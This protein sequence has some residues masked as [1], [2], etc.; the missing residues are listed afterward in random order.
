MRQYRHVE[1][2][3][4]LAVV[5]YAHGAPFT[6]RD[7]LKTAVDNCLAVNATG[8]VCCETANC[9]PA[10][11]DEMEGWDV[12]SVTD[13]Q[14]M[15]SSAWSFNANI[16]GWDVSSVTD[17]EYMFWGASAFNADIS[18]WD[19]TSVA[20]IGFMFW[21][22]SA[23]N[24]DISGWDV[25]SVEDMTGMF[26]QASAFNADISV[27]DVSSVTDGRNHDV[28]DACDPTCNCV[29]SNGFYYVFE[30]AT[31][32][33][34]T[35]VRADGTASTDGPPNAW[36]KMET[37]SPPPP[38]PPPP[39]PPSPPSAPFA[40]KADLQTA[41]Y[42][43]LS[44]D[45][46]GVACCGVSY[47]PGCGDG[48]STARCGA[49]GCDEMPSWDT[50]SVTDMWY[51]FGGAVSAFNADIS[52]WNT[53]SV[54]NMGYMFYGASAFNADISGWNTSSVTNMEYMFHGA[55]GINSYI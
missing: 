41:I 21:S 48:P 37:P 11:S 3:F 42:N 1:A 52:G 26:W 13:M 9:G 25:S 27:W 43:C 22:A 29:T 44:Y 19:T 30:K 24:T 35:F 53:S 33:T 54:T 18:G 12:S 55:L 39:A 28:C 23:F 10:G 50:S 32:W 4:L 45:Q 17:M 38:T 14:Y 49:A 46:T 51:I 7:Q 2:L 5:G 36:N 16:S 8:G 20:R 40:N 6:S 31:A 15:F 34:A 47:D